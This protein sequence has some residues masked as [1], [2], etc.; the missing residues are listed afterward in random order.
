[1][2]NGVAVFGISGA[3]G[4]ESA[5]DGGVDRD[6]GVRGIVH[7]VRDVSDC[8]GDLDVYAGHDNDCDMAE[9]ERFAVGGAN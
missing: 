3:E 2:A 5:Q 4:G 7:F 6:A 1:M 9:Y 8:A